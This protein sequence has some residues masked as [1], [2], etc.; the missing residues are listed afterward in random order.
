[1]V[2]EA[3]A[4]KSGIFAKAFLISAVVCLL[5]AVLMPEQ[6]APL[7]ESRGADAWTMV[8]TNAFFVLSG[9]GLVFLILSIVTF[10][11]GRK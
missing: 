9:C 6:V 4:P 1:M 8:R 2:A 3:Q 7:S 5:A 10:V 11:A